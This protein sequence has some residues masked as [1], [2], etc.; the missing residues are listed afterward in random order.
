VRASG[1]LAAIMAR[2]GLPRVIGLLSLLAAGA[3][4][5]GCERG[6][7]GDAPVPSPVATAPTASATPVT[8]A[9]GTVYGAGVGSAE[10]VTVA[11]L[12]AD[13]KA[14]EGRAVRVEGMVTDVCAKRGCWFD[15]AGEVPGQKLRFKVQ[16]G[17]MVFPMDAKG[18]HAVAE[19]VVKVQS[20]TLEETRD[21]V[22]Y[23]AE[24]QGR[25]VDPASITEPRVIVRL[26]GTGAV[27]AGE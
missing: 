16:D 13:P 18:K 11:A 25:A 2:P 24:E 20:L 12:L 17:V 15:L 10:A 6:P 3:L 9:P 23:E 7:R 4:F 21:Y 14:Y 1:K 27:I 19:G 26:D 22:V 8:T 5:A